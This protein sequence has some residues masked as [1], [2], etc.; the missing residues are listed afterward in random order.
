[1]D[2]Q[3]RPASQVGQI[4]SS[5]KDQKMLRPECAVGNGG[6]DH[7]KHNGKK[8]KLTFA[9]LLAKYQKDNEAKIAN[10]SNDVKY[11]RLPPRHNYEN[12]NRQKRVFIQRQHILLLSHQRR[13]HMLHIPL[14][15]NLIHHGVERFI[16]TYSFIFQTISC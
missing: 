16:D 9:E 7:V 13:F 15:L 6:K 5:L 14:V 11:S 10:R 4:G 12:W 2:Q 1:L 3:A 8:P